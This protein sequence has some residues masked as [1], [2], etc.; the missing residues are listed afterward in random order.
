MA[1]YGSKILFLLL[2]LAVI[3]ALIPLLTACGSSAAVGLKGSASVTLSWVAPE[4]N[5]DGSPLTNL[6]GYRIYYGETSGTYTD[7]VTI[8]GK[9]SITTVI[10]NLPNGS[11]IHFVV[12]AFNL[13]GNES[14]YSNEIMTTVPVTN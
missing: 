2:F 12:T 3:S 11:T 13:H 9:T 10:G 8:I 4:F 6:A 7:S 5:E 14:A 1:R